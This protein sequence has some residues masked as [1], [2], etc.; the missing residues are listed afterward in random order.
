MAYNMKK[1][2]AEEV[3]PQQYETHC[4]QMSL[5]LLSGMDRREMKHVSWLNS[6]SVF[7]T[8]SLNIGIPGWNLVGDA[9]CTAFLKVL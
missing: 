5:P 7:K 4:V 8:V 2:M 6:R 3:G 1:S 9:M